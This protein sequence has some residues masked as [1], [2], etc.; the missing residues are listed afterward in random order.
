M[1]GGLRI[2]ETLRY[3]SQVW[4][5]CASMGLGRKVGKKPFCVSRARRIAVLPVGRLFATLPSSP[6]P[7]CPH[8]VRRS[9]RSFPLISFQRCRALLLPPSRPSRVWLLRFDSSG[10]CPSPR[11]ARR[12]PGLLSSLD[13]AR[14]RTTPKE[15]RDFPSPP[16]PGRRTGR[17][18]NVTMRRRPLRR[19]CSQP[20]PI[21]SRNLV[22]AFCP[23]VCSAKLLFGTRPSLSP[24]FARRTLRALPVD[25]SFS[26]TSFPRAACP[27]L[28]RPQRVG[29]GMR[30]E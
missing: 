11:E 6:P 28:L 12:F 25:T 15:G 16:P 18:F 13:S 3:R 21:A 9:I 10:S 20:P 7:T 17:S 2:D 22:H 27:L 14:R 19:N 23:L 4:R 1:F 30:S 8:Q 29:C 26:R 5:Q 24:L